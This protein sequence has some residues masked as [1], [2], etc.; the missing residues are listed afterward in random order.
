MPKRVSFTYWGEGASLFSRGNPSS[1]FIFIDYPQVCRL[2]L[3]LWVESGS[4]ALVNDPFIDVVSMKIL[5]GVD[6]LLYGPVL[7]TLFSC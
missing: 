5:H 3:T 1:Y 2:N 7:G 4:L 6:L